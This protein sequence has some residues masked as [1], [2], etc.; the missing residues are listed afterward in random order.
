MTTNSSQPQSF[1]PAIKP[2]WMVVICLL[3]LVS[4]SSQAQSIR[5]TVRDADSREV[6]VGAAVIILGSNPVVG[7]TTDY[8]G[9]FQFNQLPAGRHS[10]RISYLG[11]EERTMPNLVLTGAKDLVLEIGLTEA[12]VSLNEIVISNKSRPNEV[13]NEM[14]VNSAHAFNMEDARRFAGSLGDPARMVSSFA[15]VTGDA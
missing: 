9:Q 7:T 13:I 6:L 5:G 15:G 12:M 4:L 2:L 14:A 8:N 3:L 11:Y 10:L 1:N